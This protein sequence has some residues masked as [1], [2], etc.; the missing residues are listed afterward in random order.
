MI[1]FS[2]LFERKRH[3]SEKKL[4]SDCKPFISSN[5]KTSKYSYKKGYDLSLGEFTY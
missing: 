3:T 1:K 2:F 4:T 5:C